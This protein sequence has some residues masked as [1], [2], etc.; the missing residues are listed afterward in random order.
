M[1]RKKTGLGIKE[2]SGRPH[3]TWRDLHPRATP[4][5]DR[6]MEEP[7]PVTTELAGYVVRIILPGLEEEPYSVTSEI[8]ETGELYERIL[9]RTDSIYE[10][11]GSRVDGC[12]IVAFRLNGEEGD[13]TV[14][15]LL[16]LCQE[17]AQALAYPDVSLSS[18]G[19]P[20]TAAA[21]VGGSESPGQEL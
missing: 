17:E 8:P 10:I 21:V 13:P 12:Y 20:A 14:E 4:A 3:W 15:E 11:Q 6:A 19:S 9:A 2:V 5:Y 1:R 18:L 16:E 7:K